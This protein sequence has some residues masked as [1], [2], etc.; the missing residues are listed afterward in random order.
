MLAHSAF[1]RALCRV[2]QRFFARFAYRMPSSTRTIALSLTLPWLLFVTVTADGGDSPRRPN[3]VFIFADDL[4]NDLGCYGDAIV[5]SPQLDR[6]AA[7]GVRFDRAYCQYPVCNPSRSSVLSGLRTESIGVYDN[8]TPPR[9]HR[10]DVAF[11]P[12]WFR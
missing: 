1:H 10:P 4:N 3:V 12:Q 6:L 2:W 9:S 7:R 5:R 8:L 11:L